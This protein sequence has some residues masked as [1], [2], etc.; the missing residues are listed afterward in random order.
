MKP[1]ILCAD[2]YGLSQPINDAV[3][4]LIE[5]GKL[6]AT[7]CIV[8]SDY[9]PNA[10]ESIKPFYDRVQVGLHLN[11]TE[12]VPLTS[13]PKGHFGPLS[14]LLFRSHLR[15]L[16]Q[17][18][19]EN[20]FEAQLTTFIR[21]MGNGP[22]FIDG[23]QYIHQLPVIR[24]AMLNVY[25]QKFKSIKP[26]IRVPANTIFTTLKQSF[27]Q[28]KV[29][30]VA[31]NGAFALRRRLKKLSIPSNTSFSGIYNFHTKTS[32]SALFAKFL[33]RIDDYG[34]IVCHPAKPSRDATYKI[35][36]AR[37]KEYFYFKQLD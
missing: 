26:Y 13:L 31:F 37:V 35:D 15:C 23:H 29:L 30:L 25:Q 9:F 2:D 21:H 19:L 6:Q 5:L 34:L 8:T 7:S 1:F 16:N 4:E 10:A 24:E 12:G 22:D 27:E 18:A 17:K 3:L 36:D 28:P 14:G 11:L 20:E 32:Y 33:T